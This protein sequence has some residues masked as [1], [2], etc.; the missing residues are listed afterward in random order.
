MAVQ[1]GHLILMEVTSYPILYIIA[2][3]LKKM[4]VRLLDFHRVNLISF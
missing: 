3:I 1:S 2:N 4:Y